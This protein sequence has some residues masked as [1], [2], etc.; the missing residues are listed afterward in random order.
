MPEADP[1]GSSQEEGSITTGLDSKKPLAKRTKQEFTPGADPNG[2]SQEE[3]DPCPQEFG[4]KTSTLVPSESLLEDASRQ[5]REHK[6]V[7]SNGAAVPEYLW[8]EHLIAGSKVRDWDARTMNDLKTVSSW[9]REKMLGW[10]KRKVLTP[11]VCWVK[12]KYNIKEPSA[13]AIVKVDLGGKGKNWYDWSRD[14]RHLYQ[15]WWKERLV[16][17]IE[18]IVPASNVIARA[19]NCSSWG[20]G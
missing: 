14:G 20:L 3:G 2:S 1:N 9:L 5:N 18:D 10:W 15:K 11:Y 16:D 17:T 8:T 4:H 13:E 12:A 7:K 6:A 19:A